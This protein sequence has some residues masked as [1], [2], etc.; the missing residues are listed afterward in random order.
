MQ[1]FGI[2]VLGCRLAATSLAHKNN[3]EVLSMEAGICPKCKA[4]MFQ[5]DGYKEC[6]SCKYR[7]NND[8]TNTS[9]LNRNY[10]LFNN[11]NTVIECKEEL[12]LIIRNYYQKT[13][14]ALFTGSGVA[15]IV[16]ST[17][18]FFYFTSGQA[19]SDYLERGI[20]QQ[21]L[22]IG[23]MF[24]MCGWF[25]F[26]ISYYPWRE[27][28]TK[29]AKE[30]VDKLF[31][32]NSEI[33][34][35]LITLIKSSN[36]LV[37]SCLRQMLNITSSATDNFNEKYNKG[38]IK[39][40]GLFKEYLIDNAPNYFQGTL[41]ESN[42]K[43][44]YLFESEDLLLLKIKYL[45]I[46]K[47][48]VSIIGIQPTKK[49]VKLLFTFPFLILIILI[50]LLLEIIFGYGLSIFIQ[51]VGKSIQSLPERSKDPNPFGIF[52]IILLSLIILSA[53]ISLAV[54]SWG[55][56]TKY[57][58]YLPFQK[59]LTEPYLM[60][61]QAKNIVGLS[62]F[63]HPHKKKNILILAINQLNKKI[64][65]E[66]LSKDFES[67]EQIK[68]FFHSLLNLKTKEKNQNTLNEFSKG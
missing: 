12:N 6:W 67:N 29:K 20:I 68:I 56:L 43:I 50:T 9:Y 42:K 47:D 2:A 4:T 31:P 36:D 22:M 53:P 13:K 15:L 28:I 40:K 51:D 16:L 30:K 54:M 45:K 5:K 33:R 32:L 10:S 19:K 8:S 25:P 17:I 60:N 65:I 14:F 7:I 27:R 35:D 57:L 38:E 63:S 66:I 21:I 23:G 46:N 61:A 11:K 26:A 59:K 55:Y 48:C 52:F 34:E 44:K 1:L 62:L 24:M 37:S 49:K 3:Q 41:P 58:I 18:L 39:Y 64:K